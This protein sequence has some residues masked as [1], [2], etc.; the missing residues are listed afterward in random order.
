M[1]YKKGYV[2]ELMEQG[3]PTNVNPSAL[4]PSPSEITPLK[5]FCPHHFS[6]APCPVA[7][8]NPILPGSPPSHQ[9]LPSLVQILP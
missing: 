8:F 5:T 2:Y 4:F 7:P 9:C 1:E 6:P 3:G